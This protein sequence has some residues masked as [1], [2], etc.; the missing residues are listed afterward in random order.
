MRFAYFPGC[1]APGSAIEFEMSTQA[2]LEPLGLQFDEIP[3]WICCGATMGHTTDDNLALALPAK[4]LLNAREMG[5]GLE[6]ATV[7]AACY[8]R[9]RATNYEVQHREDRR[10]AVARILGEEYGGDVGVRHLLDIVVNEIGT[11]AL[12]EKATKKL[13]GLKVASYYGCLL[14]RPPK[15]VAFDDPEEPR[16]M[17]R[18]VD[19]IGGEP[20]DWTHRTECC[21]GS[22]TLSKISIVRRL[23]NDILSAAKDAGAE[24]IIAACPVCQPNLDLRQAEVEKQYGEDYGIPVLYFTQ[25]LGLSLG[26]SPEAIGLDKVIVDPRPLLSAKGLI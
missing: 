10:A 13:G 22:F 12:S 20:V 19:A 14:V 4:V 9:L 24:C 18:L 23:V 15:M 1:T 3:N 25:L 6:V 2:V 26:A 7:C 16:S 21:G 17:D 11:E 5:G 8:N